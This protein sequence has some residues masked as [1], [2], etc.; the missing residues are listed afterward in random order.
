MEKGFEMRTLAYV[1]LAAI[2]LAFA[3]SVAKAANEGLDRRIVLAAGGGYPAKSG[4]VLLA[5]RLRY[6]PN[7]PFALEFNLYAPYGF[8]LAFLLDVYRNDRVRI[9]AFDLGFFENIPWLRVNNPQVDRFFDLTL[10][11]GIEWNVYGRHIVS[12]DWRAFLPDPTKVPF[13]YGNYTVPIYRDAI[14]GGQIWLGYI[15]DLD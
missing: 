5:A 3:S 1:I 14:A 10:G 6:L 15:F 8:G 7:T 11:A 2:G 9:H 12:L 13:R 4:G